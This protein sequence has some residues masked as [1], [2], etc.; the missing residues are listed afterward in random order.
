MFFE[1]STNYPLL[2]LL[3]SSESLLPK[4]SYFHGVYVCVCA[5]N[6]GCWQEYDCRV[7]YLSWVPVAASLRNITPHS[8]QP[9]TACKLPW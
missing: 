9:L 8:L 3:L 2:F 1:Q 7:S 5:F 4:F 6:Y